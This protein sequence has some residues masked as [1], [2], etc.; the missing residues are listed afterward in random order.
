VQWRFLGLSMAGYNVLISLLM[1]LLA[2][3]GI[4]RLSRR[5]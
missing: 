5:A 3:F 4:K 2:L 1:A